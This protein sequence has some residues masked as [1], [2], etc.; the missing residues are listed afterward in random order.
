L[1]VLEKHM[2]KNTLSLALAKVVI[3]AAWA[4]GHLSGDEVNSLKDLLYRMLKVDPERE[5][6]L[7]A[8]E[9]SLLELY[10]AS[11]VGAE[12]R[13]RLVAELQAELRG[14]RDRA[15]AIAAL[16]QLISA[17]GSISEAERAVVAELRQAL[18]STDLGL[19]A[20]L[21]RLIGGPLARRTQAVA[22]APNR[23]EQLEDF[24]RNRIYFNLRQRLAAEGGSLTL[25]EGELRKLSLAGGLMARV[26][27]VDEAVSAEEQ[28]SMV[29]ALE[30]WGLSA[31]AATLVAETAVSTV[32]AGL[33][34]F[35]LSREF[36]DLTEENERAG[37]LD[38]LFAVADADGRLS[39]EEN[40]EIR[41]IA[42]HLNL[43]GAQFADAKDRRKRA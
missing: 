20:Q 43:S 27:N 15:L 42:L 14:P 11:P 19:F 35:R 31:A 40:E 10:M 22:S 12:E 26:A 7:S 23:E 33:D 17:D 5:I 25:A 18:E 34:F 21:S 24:V 39:H 1:L 8:K 38:V 32:A 9:W 13:A 30:G 28:G 37:F 4:D 6:D 16:E 41:R 3:A 2:A 36:A 29:R